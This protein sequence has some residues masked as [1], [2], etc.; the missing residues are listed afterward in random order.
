M[1][2]ADVKLPGTADVDEVNGKPGKTC[3]DAMD[4]A[5][6][7]QTAAM[8]AARHPKVIAYLQ[9]GWLEATN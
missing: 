6:S 7:T 4:P 9:L 3:A 1:I 5:A 8:S 2:G